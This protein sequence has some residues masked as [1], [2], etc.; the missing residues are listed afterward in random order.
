MSTLPT[1]MDI[2][3]K[4]YLNI[5]PVAEQVLMYL[6]FVAGTI[7]ILVTTYIL[8]FEIMFKSYGENKHNMGTN[9]W[10]D[11]EKRCKT[12]SNNDNIYA[13]CEI[14]LSDTDSDQKIEET[15]PTFMKS[16]SE[17]LKELGH[18]LSD[19]FHGSVGN[20]RGRFDDLTHVKDRK[21]SLITP[22][23]S[24]DGNND[25]YKTDSSE[26]DK[27]YDRYQEVKQTDTDDDCRYLE[28]IDDGSE[29][30][31]DSD[32]TKKNTNE[33]YIHID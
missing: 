24:R 15:K 12:K 9:L 31:S 7:L 19:K 20:I 29:F 30:D 10:L 18:R 23:E 8:T 33:T 17:R 13:A 6:S 1:S 14:P 26:S 4:F 22:E 27:E 3:F 11:R 28:V 21:N 25:A 5:L 32:R 2:K 16:Q